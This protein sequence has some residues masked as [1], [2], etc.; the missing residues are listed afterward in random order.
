[1]VHISNKISEFYLEGIAYITDAG[2]PDTHFSV[3]GYVLHLFGEPISR[4]LKS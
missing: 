3:Y 2:N 1:M 4:K